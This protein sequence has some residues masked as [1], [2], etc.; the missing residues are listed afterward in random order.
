M[1][2]LLLAL[3]TSVMQGFQLLVGYISNSYTFPKP[4]TP[5]E[6]AHYLTLY[7]E[8]GDTD[9]KNILV[10]RNL[11]LV[12]HIAKKYS[13]NNYLSTDDLISIGTIGLIK[14]ITTYD[15]SKGV[16]LATYASRC[17]ANEILMVLR[18]GNKDKNDVYLQDPIGSDKEGGTISL[19][20]ILS[21]E[22][23]NIFDNLIL[24][25]QKQK[26]LDFY[27]TLKN[28]EKLILKLRYGLFNEDVKKQREIAEMLGI[29]RSY[30]S[31]I[32]KKALSKLKKAFADES[33]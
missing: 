9:A 10:E 7:K 4:L 29:S 11:R 3:L 1:F 24:K 23:D 33:L 21:V 27:V 2:G 26:L 14:A 25:T 18:S 13:A 31:R 8:K 6:E 12:A 30:V 20:D 28:R 15:G 5:E 19:L 17:I 32:E 22:D 16:H